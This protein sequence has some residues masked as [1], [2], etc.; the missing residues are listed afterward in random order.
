MIKETIYIKNMV[1]DR[2]IRVVKEELDKLGIQVYGIKLG[3]VH[4][5]SS[6]KINRQQLAETLHKAGF[7]LLE[8]K[9]I[10][11]V[12][13]IKTLI[14]D[15]IHHHPQELTGTFSEYISHQIGKD[16]HYLS[17]LFSSIENITIE[18]YTILQKIEKV[19]EYLV[20]DELNLSEISY[21]LGYSS[22]AHLSSQFKQV[23]GLTPTEFKK[24]KDRPRN[25]LDSVKPN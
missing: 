8:D 20:Y 24:L 19:K 12:E 18:K 9:N 2:C 7:E 14:I 6:D 1:C 17:S 15:S 4:I 11:L 23:T 22:V 25:S 10:R 21:K 5:L 16:Y 13:K 3:E